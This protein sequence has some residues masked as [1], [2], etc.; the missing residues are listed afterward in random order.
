MAAVSTGLTDYGVDILL[1][2]GVFLPQNYL[3]V[4]STN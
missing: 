2:G 1:L 3:L 4:D